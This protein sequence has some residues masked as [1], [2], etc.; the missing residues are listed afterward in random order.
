MFICDFGIEDQFLGVIIQRFSCVLEF[1]TVEPLAVN[2]C[3]DL[4]DELA[5]PFESPF[6]ASY[7]SEILL[8]CTCK[9]FEGGNLKL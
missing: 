8:L 6:F 2:E 1:T 5:G 9:G 4:C 3:L 7:L